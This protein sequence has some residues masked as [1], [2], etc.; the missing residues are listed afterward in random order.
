MGTDTWRIKVK[1]DMEE[2][3]FTSE[4]QETKEGL[5][6]GGK[7]KGFKTL[8]RKAIWRKNQLIFGHC[9]CIVN[10]ISSLV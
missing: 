7:T 8:L 4:G 2:R 3:Y 9:R 10:F 1:K 6:L 5:C